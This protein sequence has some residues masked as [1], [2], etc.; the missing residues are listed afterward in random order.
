MADAAAHG[1]IPA[2]NPLPLAANE[3][4]D[5]KTYVISGIP[6]VYGEP[7]NRRIAVRT[8]TITVYNKSTL[9]RINTSGILLDKP[10]ASAHNCG[11]AKHRTIS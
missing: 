7:G 3:I 5:N 2:H 6:V 8:D 10:A 4:G 9:Y 11:D 1:L